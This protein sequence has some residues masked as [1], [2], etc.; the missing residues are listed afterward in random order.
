MVEVGSVEEAVEEAAASDGSVGVST[1]SIGANSVASP[2]PRQG[3]SDFIVVLDPGHG[4][5]DGG[6]SSY[7]T[8]KGI[9]LEIAKACRDE[10]L[11]YAGVQVYMTREDDTFVSLSDRVQFAV[12]HDADLVVSI[13]NNSSTSS[14][15]RG[16]EVIVPREGNWYYEETFVTGNQLGEKI[17]SKLEALGLPRTG[18]GVYDKDC[19]NDSRYPDGTLSDYFTLIAGPREYGI[20]GIIVEHAFVSNPT[21]AAY[22]SNIENLKALGRADAQAIV[23]QY[24]LTKWNITDIDTPSAV[25]VGTEVTMFPVTSGDV[26][27][28]RYNYGWQRDG[29]W[30]P[31]D[32]NSTLSAT[33]QYTYD[34]SWS[35]KPEK[36]G[37]YTLFV[38]G[39]ILDSQGNVTSSKTVRKQLVVT[40]WDLKGIKGVS[41]KMLVGDSVTV[42]P[43]I[44]GDTSGVTYNYIWQ[45]DNWS[46]WGSTVN[47]TGEGTTA[48][49]WA[50]SPKQ[51][52]TYTLYVDAD[53]G[54][55]KST[56]ESDEIT[57]SRFAATGVEAPS[58]AATGQEVSF[59]AI[60][61]GDLSGAMYNYVWQRD[62]SWAEGDWGSTVLSTGGMTSSSTGSFS[63]GKAGTYTLAVDV[64]VGGET[65]TVFSGEVVVTDPWTAMGIDGVPEVI[66]VG[67][68]ITLKPNV[69]GDLAGVTYNYVWQRNGSWEPGE[70]GSTVESTG[71]ATTADTWD[72]T[73]SELGIYT[74]YVDVH[75]G[76]YKQTIQATVIVGHE[77]MGVSEA[78]KQSMIDYLD[79]Y[80]SKPG[81]SYPDVYASKGAEGVEE[82]VD[83]L[84]SVATSEGVRPDVAFSQMIVETG[85]LQFGGDVG[86]EQCNFAGIGATGSG[87]SGE[88]FKDVRE[89]LL[90]QVQHL[91][92]Y[93][94]TDPLINDKVDPRFDYVKRG[95]AKYIEELTGTWATSSTYAD[96]II[97][98]LEQL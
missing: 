10:L 51:A 40:P 85:G 33:G 55:L 98:V 76:T 14:A 92:A 1:L 41:R 17:L 35:F 70:W 67:E 45:R 59:K 11:Q 12:D 77:I 46:D 24:G 83:I 96:S 15:P 7:V 34:S 2:E 66:G 39:V 32:W 54:S 91:K 57:V 21:D 23:E 95:C 65:Q 16:C 26:S 89:G 27:S 87:V 97:A 6:A 28:V 84:W 19:T 93:A 68:T 94:S 36:P 53:N 69:T 43:V 61:K 4:G 88:S 48:S 62:G 9:N 42:S 73:P 3:S 38:D 75:S 37:T 8:E 63:P 86:A 50:F 29:S 58:E 31:G 56:V 5:Y 78:S 25:M 90:A 74:L 52:G 13:H 71:F 81:N 80:C 47:S 18:N 79:D 30:E 72:F 64:K 20:L 49:S 22:L 82:F 60:T 44:S